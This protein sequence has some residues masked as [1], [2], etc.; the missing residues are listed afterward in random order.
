[1]KTFAGL[2]FATMVLASSS[3]AF[4]ACSTPPIAHADAYNMPKNTYIIVYF[5]DLVLN[6]YDP[7]VNA[8]MDSLSAFGIPSSGVCG[9]GP[10]GFCY[11][12]PTNFTGLVSIPYQVED[13][14]GNKDGGDILI[15]VQ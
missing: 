8:G 10:T 12:P 6:D 14:C 7:D 9:V 1:M 2:F 11:A 3:N 5:N 4:A 15:F 13:T